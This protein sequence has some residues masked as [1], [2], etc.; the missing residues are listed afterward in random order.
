[1]QEEFYEFYQHYLGETQKI[2]SEVFKRKA[3]QFAKLP[4][5][6]VPS[7]AVDLSKEEIETLAGKLALFPASNWRE[8]LARNVAIR[9]KEADQQW[10]NSIAKMKKRTG[11]LDQVQ[12]YD[13]PGAND[14]RDFLF[15]WTHGADLALSPNLANTVSVPGH[16]YFLLTRKINDIEAP[17]PQHW[18]PLITAE[19]RRI[20][21]GRLGLDR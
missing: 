17:P 15:M 1:M 4:F 19:S 14:L 8:A 2:H 6:P 21:A 5:G 9:I 13:G 12:Y 3:L 20:T 7:E 11:A 16:H 10:M 18:R